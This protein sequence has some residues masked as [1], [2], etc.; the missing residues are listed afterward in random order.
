MT[1]NTES[2]QSIVV[3][4]SNEVFAKNFPLSKKE[5]SHFAVR[6]EHKNCSLLTKEAQK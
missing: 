3:L 2:P 6:D 4:F 1:F 5:A